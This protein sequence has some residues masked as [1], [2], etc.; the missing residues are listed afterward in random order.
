MANP[1][2]LVGT[3]IP[4]LVGTSIPELGLVTK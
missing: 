4:K 3:S 1:P 2:K